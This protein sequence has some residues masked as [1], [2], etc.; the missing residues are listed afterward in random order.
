MSSPKVTHVSLVL[1]LRGLL[2]SA[3]VAMDR[4]GDGP[5]RSY[6]KSLL[7]GNLSYHFEPM[8]RHTRTD[9]RRVFP[10]APFLGAVAAYNNIEY[11]E[12]AK[13]MTFAS[14]TNLKTTNS[15]LLEA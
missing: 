8:A 5:G 3:S 1:A 11:R 14:R 2:A 15:N 4:N 6:R 12:I 9:N 10:L 7:L 13:D